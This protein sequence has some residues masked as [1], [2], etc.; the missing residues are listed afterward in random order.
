MF[1]YFMFYVLFYFCL[2]YFGVSVLEVFSL[3]VAL[4]I[5]GIHRGYWEDPFY[6]MGGALHPCTNGNMEMQDDG[7]NQAS[8]DNYLQSEDTGNNWFQNPDVIGHQAQNAKVYFW[9]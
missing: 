8:N 5:E 4:G 1:P 3:H 2:S 9:I 7:K 6:K